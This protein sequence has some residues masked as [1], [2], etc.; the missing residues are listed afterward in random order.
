VAYPSRQGTAGDFL[1]VGLFHRNWW[2]IDG[3]SDRN[4]VQDREPFFDP[5]VIARLERTLIENDLK[6]EAFFRVNGITP[7]VVSY[8]DLASDYSGVILRIVDWLGARGA[9]ATSIRRSRFTR[10]S[11][12]RNEEWL[13]RY[14][15]FK[16]DAGHLA[17]PSSPIELSSPLDERSTWPL[18]VIPE[19][20]KR[21]IDHNKR[22]KT[23]DS[24]IVEVLASNGYSRQAAIAEVVAEKPS[25]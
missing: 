3:A 17:K 2:L 6:W 22:L 10:Q 7:L 5:H 8:E 12:K 15:A 16:A 18:D 21:W 14:R 25:A 9:D 20:W 23:P 1:S 4:K 11:N 13:D 24:E 19:S